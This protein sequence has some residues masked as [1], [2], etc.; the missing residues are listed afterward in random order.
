MTSRLLLALILVA[1]PLASDAMAQ[2]P[3]RT[4]GGPGDEQLGSIA[5]TADGGLVLVGR[6]GPAGDYNH[7]DAQVL[8]LDP[9]GNI[10]WQ[11]TYGSP[12]V[13]EWA[14][15]VVPTSD[16]G[17]VVLGGS[18]AHPGWT[19]GSTIWMLK[20]D[21]DGGVVWQKS[22]GAG[23][24]DIG[25][26]IKAT[27]D[28]GFVVAGTTRAPGISATTDGL[29][30]KINAQGN[31]LWSRSFGSPG[32]DGFTSVNIAANGDLLVTGRLATTPNPPYTIWTLWVLRL[33]ASGQ[34]GCATCWQKSF[35]G[36]TG[37]HGELTADGGLI[38]VG[39]QAPFTDND[40]ILLR[41]DG[42]GN[43]LWEKTFGTTF[44]DLVSAIVVT[45]DGGFLLAVRTGFHCTPDGACPSG[46]ADAWLLKLDAAGVITAQV[47]AG[48]SG[49]D[50]IGGLLA[51]SD[52]RIV[53]VGNTTSSGA[54]GIDL[55][56]LNLDAGLGLGTSC[57]VRAGNAV[58]AVPVTPSHTDTATAPAPVPLVA[59]ATTA[60]SAVST[61]VARDVCAATPP[62]RTW[63]RRYGKTSEWEVAAQVLPVAGGGFL[64]AA[65]TTVNLGP[66]DVLMMSLDDGGEIRWQNRYG[67][68]NEDHAVAM[69]PT[70]DGG[71]VV[72][73][74][75]FSF[76][77]RA[78][79]FFVMKTDA[80]GSVS[81]AA[82][83]ARTYGGASMEQAMA[84]QQ[85]AD[86]GYMVAGT[87]ESGYDAWVI[88]IDGTGAL[89]WQKTY[90]GSRIDLIEGM[91]QT[92]DG[93]VILVGRTRSFGAG[94][95]DLW[96]LKLDSA[97]MPQWQKTYGGAAAD[98]GRAILQ[99]ADGGYVVAGST[100]STGAGSP[101][102]WILKIDA[103]G[104]SAPT[105]AGCWQKTYG[106]SGYDEA[107]AI[108]ATADGGFVVVG[109]TAGAVNQDCLLMKLDAS[110]GVVWSK[111]YGGPQAGPGPQAE[112]C[113]AVQVLP[114]GGF[115]VAGTSTMTT[116]GATDVLVLRLDANGQTTPSCGLI[117]NV[118]LTS[119]GSNVAAAASTPTVGQLSSASGASQTV[120]VQ[121]YDLTSTLTCGAPAAA[122]S[123]RRIA[124]ILDGKRG[125]AA[126]EAIVQSW[127]QGVCPDRGR[128]CSAVCASPAL[129]SAQKIEISKDV[130]LTC[131][132]GCPSTCR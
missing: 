127:S 17:F 99:T 35:D 128:V 95:F 64:V 65:T 120:P 33:D 94:D 43:A 112:E 118:A 70:S 88:K 77:V 114:D 23:A 61:A 132:I 68:T 115:I 9:A 103:N 59:A 101:D 87:T 90:G 27:S 22:Y 54:G 83:W 63:T 122:A 72:A 110:G 36:M 53:A 80:A 124:Q 100:A 55:W 71:F 75:T 89:V 30:F 2:P 130:Q 12:E 93:G 76:G 19:P 74:Y 121:A 48:G 58:A 26:T 97:G 119:G 28:G 67:G 107:R 13:L 106:T 45:P 117:T 46:P 104:E 69:A 49:D 15:A 57:M 51:R 126:T 81:C 47:L 116:G 8:R 96:L 52:G 10:V 5:P 105:C 20:L 108:Q 29:L 37:G 129:T 44:D 60:P 50:R 32:F 98:V 24:E 78:G 111:I 113:T 16:G 3:V 4:Y 102:V 41:L 42:S 86:G 84:I 109:T 31:L 73:G 56:T 25:S 66:T 82:C 1:P 123:A 92:S 40:V 125:M 34:P 14:T 18:D 85:S 38:V 91:R 79:D 11:K 131:G 6:T 21:R 62:A 39:Y 7:A